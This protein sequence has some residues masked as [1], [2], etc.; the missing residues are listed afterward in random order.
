MAD[1][2]KGLSE[3][4]AGMQSTMRQFQSTIDSLMQANANNAKRAAEAIAKPKR[5]IRENGR[6]VGIEPMKG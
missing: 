3:A 4:V 2:V 5:V 6:I 1:T